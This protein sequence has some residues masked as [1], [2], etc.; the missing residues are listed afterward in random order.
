MAVLDEANRREVW[1]EFMRELSADRENIGVNK[2]DLRAAVDALDDFMNTNAAAINNA[3]PQPAKAQL[4]TAQKALLLNYVVYRRW[5]A[6][7]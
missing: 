2:V 1:A 5:I 7:A 6:G 3:F 4:T